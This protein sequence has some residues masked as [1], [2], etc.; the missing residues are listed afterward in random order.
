MTT[1][2]R[3]ETVCRKLSFSVDDS[4]PKEPPGGRV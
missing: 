3:A 4:G 2:D 1:L